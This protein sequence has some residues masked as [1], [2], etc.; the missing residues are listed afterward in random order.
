MQTIINQSTKDSTRSYYSAKWKHFSTWA[1]Q[2]NLSL[3]SAGIPAILE[4]WLTLKSSVLVFS[5]LWM[6]LA[7]ICT[8]HPLVDNHTIFTHPVTTRFLK[9]ILRP[10]PLAVELTPQWDLNFVQLFLT[11]TP[12][13][14]LGTCSVTHLSM[15]V[16]A[17][18]YSVSQKSW[19]TGSGYGGPTMC[20]LL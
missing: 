5:C 18:S 16:I 4:Y 7:A 1:H 15:K 12:F 19:W 11:K 13:E 17:D 10:F 8:F 20:Y 3:D 2:S 9:G 14:L 6:H